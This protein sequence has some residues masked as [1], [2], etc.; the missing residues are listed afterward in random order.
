MLTARAEYRL[1]LRADNAATRL[2]PIALEMGCVGDRRRDWFV[3]RE[4]DL[5][6][7]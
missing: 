6:A 7:D 3:S 1:R 5:V 2:T 4:T